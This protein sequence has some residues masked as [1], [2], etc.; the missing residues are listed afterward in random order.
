M[1]ALRERAAGKARVGLVHDMAMFIATQEIPE[2]G[3]DAEALAL[4]LINRYEKEHGKI[5]DAAAVD[6]AAQAALPEHEK[7]LALLKSRRANLQRDLDSAKQ[8]KGQYDAL[9]PADDVGD[10]SAEI[11]EVEGMLVK[12]K[13]DRQRI[14]NERLN[15]VA[16]TKGSS[17]AKAKTKQALAH[18]DDVMA[19]T[20]VADALAPN[21][22]PAEML[23]DALAPVN[24]ALVQAALDTE[25][26]EVAIAPDMAIT[27]AGRPYQLLSESEQWRTDAMIAQV[28]AE[29][30]GVKLLMLDRVDVLDLPGRAQLLE[31]VD[32]LAFLNLVDTVLLFGTFKALPTGLADTVTA[33]WIENGTI[34]G[35]TIEQQAAS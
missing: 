3:A 26:M 25:W 28:V 18:H 20:K 33:Y 17:E 19:W 27:A 8:A 5:E 29:L 14:E 24:A 2:L 1:V 13:A 11:A 4:G 34:A 6:T 31:W 7:G 10:A 15:I 21:G 12:A 22:I 23:L 16:A 35:S 9:A 30:S 32:N